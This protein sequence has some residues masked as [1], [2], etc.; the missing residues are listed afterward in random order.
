MKINLYVNR[1]GLEG[2][3]ENTVKLM[4]NVGSNTS[5]KENILQSPAIHWIMFMLSL[6]VSWRLRELKIPI[7]QCILGDMTHE[8]YK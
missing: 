7:C 8:S 1:K 3:F 6:L 4:I 5:G 2:D